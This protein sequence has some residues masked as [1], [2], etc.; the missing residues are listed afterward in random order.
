MKKLTIL[1]II[2]LLLVVYGYYII[3]SPSSDTSKM[4]LE[5]SN[6]EVVGAVDNEIVVVEPRKG[7]GTLESLRVLNEDLECTISHTNN[8]VT[9]VEGTYF[10]SD[11]NM[12]GDF[13]TESP[14]L[15]GKILSSMIVKD[16]T[17]YTWSE[18]EG[19]VYGVK[20][21]LTTT[22]AEAAETKQPFSLNDDVK[23]DCK[24]WKNVDRTVFAPPNDVLFQ[25]MSDLMKAGMEEATLYEE[26]EEMSF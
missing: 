5:H 1:G 12:R 18:I 23:Y 15:L 7:T 25:D 21:D 6:V 22:D 3:F 4:V 10:V 2:A 13:L 24:N 19:K 9:E 8:Q 11:G 26:G 16:T 14:D 17:M 20:M